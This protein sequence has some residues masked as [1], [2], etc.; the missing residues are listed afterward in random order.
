[1]GGSSAVLTMVRPAKV[2][3]LPPAS[4]GSTSLVYGLYPRRDTFL[5]YV[6]KDFLSTEK[7]RGAAR[8]CGGGACGMIG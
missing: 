1:M 4:I 5:L 6:S 8:L 7:N 2:P 3:L